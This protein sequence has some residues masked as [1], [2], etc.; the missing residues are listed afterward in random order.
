MAK[1]YDVP[2]V[3]IVLS[4]VFF[5]V[6]SVTSPGL[7]ILQSYCSSCF[8]GAKNVPIPDTVDGFVQ[9]LQLLG[10]R[11]EQCRLPARLYQMQ[12]SYGTRKTI[13]LTASGERVYYES[14]I[15]RN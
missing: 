9:F 15:W 8:D 13:V 10:G 14:Q 12:Y 5:L 11:S 7:N 1:L 2:K 6:G 4:L 3:Q